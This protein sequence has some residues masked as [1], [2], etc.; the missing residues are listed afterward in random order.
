M[1]NLYNLY[2]LHILLSQSKTRL[3]LAPLCICGSDV[4]LIIQLL[5]GKT[6]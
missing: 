1:Y 4:D 2:N 5:F 6:L 3:F